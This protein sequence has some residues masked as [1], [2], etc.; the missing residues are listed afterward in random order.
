MSVISR[1]IG[2]VFV[3]LLTSPIL[4]AIID[5]AGYFF[6]NNSI[7]EIMWKS[8]GAW[9]IFIIMFYTLLMGPCIVAASFGLLEDNRGR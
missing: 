1:I 5:V 6:I 4:A 9:R 8:D 7:T 2:W 3:L